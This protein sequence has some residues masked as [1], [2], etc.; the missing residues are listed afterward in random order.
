[1]RRDLLVLA[2]L[3]LLIRLPFLA[4][5]IQGDDVYYLAMAANGLVDPLHPM[6]MA[7]VYQ[8]Q[9][10]WM[11]GHS[12]PPLNNYILLALLT[13]FGGVHE[14]AFHAVYMTFSLLAV[15]AVYFLARRFTSHPLLAAL[16]FLAVPAFVLSGNKLEADLPFLALWLVGFALLYMNGRCGP[17]C[18]WGSRGWPPIKQCSPFRFWPAGSGK[19]NPAAVG[20]C[21]SGPTRWRCSRRCLRWEHGSYSKWPRGRKCPLPSSRDITPRGTSLVLSGACAT[22]WL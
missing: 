8:G 15:G 1:M 10:I 11:A 4:Q 13:V 19:Q 20:E 2:G 3:V 18:R 9:H 21:A 7:Y 17:L 14:T 22:P 16:L 5:P 12:H 6:Q